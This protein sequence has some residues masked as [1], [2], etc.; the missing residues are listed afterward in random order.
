[1]IIIFPIHKTCDFCDKPAPSWCFP[2]Q[3]FDAS[4]GVVGSLG[5]WSACETCH[6]LIEGGNWSAL[7]NRCVELI[8]KDS[9]R[10]ESCLTEMLKLHAKFARHR[11]GDPFRTDH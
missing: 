6:D 10:H 5:E 2:A 1:M 4:P 11:T 7:A 8:C 9:S 3:S